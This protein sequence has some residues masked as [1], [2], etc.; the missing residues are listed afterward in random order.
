[1]ISDYFNLKDQWEEK[2]IV[3]LGYDE[4]LNL[5]SDLF[6]TCPEDKYR[7]SPFVLPSSSKVFT[8]FKTIL[9]LLFRGD[10]K[11]SFENNFLMN[12]NNALQ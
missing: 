9:I 5:V 4:D 12:K 3:N 1:M 11:N 2:K 8:E 10:L 7:G 6:N